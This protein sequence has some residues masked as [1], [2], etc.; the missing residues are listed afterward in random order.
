VGIIKGQNH[1]NN[2]KRK[3]EEKIKVHIEMNGGGKTG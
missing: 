3:E 1:A 2:Q